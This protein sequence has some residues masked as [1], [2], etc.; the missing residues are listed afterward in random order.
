MD[1]LKVIHVR[2]HGGLSAAR[3]LWCW[4]TF[5]FSLRHLVATMAICEFTPKE[6]QKPTVPNPN[7][8]QGEQ[9]DYELLPCATLGKPKLYNRCLFHVEYIQWIGITVHKN[10]PV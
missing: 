7:S 1:I 3:L 4:E 5:Q 2:V 10:V 8:Q 9:Q 6:M